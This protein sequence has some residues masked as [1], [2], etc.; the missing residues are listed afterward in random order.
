[1]AIES[2]FQY[3][4]RDG[5]V[6]EAYVWGKTAR[7]KAVIQLAHGMGEHAQRYLPP[8]K[9]LI[10][11]GYTIYANDHRG[12]G[13]TASSSEDLGNYGPG[14]YDIV[15]DDMVRLTRLAREEN[16]TAPIILLGH[17]MGSMLGQGYLLEHADLLVGAAFSGTAAVDH[18]A[19]LAA[20]PR[21][22]AAIN[23]PFEPA[24]TPFEWLSRDSDEVDA[25]IADPFC[26]FSLNQESMI[27]LF[28]KGERLADPARLA[29]IPKGFPI[30]IFAGANDP[31]NANGEWIQP[32]ID[33]YKAVGANVTQDIYPGA[34]HEVLN[35]TNRSEVVANLMRW[36]NSVT[37]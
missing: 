17:S 21:G 37:K 4:G 28:G 3:A 5:R 19:R 30:Y 29:R 8:L 13:R 6:I 15:V 7:P 20:D 11:V 23:A 34:R 36:L 22:L 9:P 1:M 35:E 10:E 14:G 12:H 26:G 25:Y 24:R 18:L 2:R 32:L 27:E 16:P 31:V 33:R